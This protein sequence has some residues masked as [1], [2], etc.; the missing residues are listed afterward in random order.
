MKVLIE[1]PSMVTVGA[2]EAIEEKLQ[3][4]EKYHLNITQVEVYFRKDDGRG[5]E[6]FLSEIRV[7][8][9]GDDLFVKE[10]GEEP[11]EAFVKALKSVDNLALKRKER[12][13]EH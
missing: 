3:K 10:S 7:H 11:M 13:K 1:T 4:L 2:R 9:P 5:R 12:M 8:L 6:S